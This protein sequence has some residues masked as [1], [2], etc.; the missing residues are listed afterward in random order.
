M[1]LPLKGKL[2]QFTATIDNQILQ[3]LVY[4]NV[5][6]TIYIFIDFIENM[7]NNRVDLKMQYLRKPLAYRDNASCFLQ[8][9]FQ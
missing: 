2:L 6:H 4:Y 7:V 8:G 5:N 1:L 9:H 3:D